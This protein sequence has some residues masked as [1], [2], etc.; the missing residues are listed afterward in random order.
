[1]TKGSKLVVFL[2]KNAHSESASFIIQA[3]MQ[4]TQHPSCSAWN[5]VLRVSE[6]PFSVMA[7]NWH[8]QHRSRCCLQFVRGTLHSGRWRAVAGHGESAKASIL[9]F[10]H[11]FN[12][13]VRLG[14]YTLTFASTQPDLSTD[15]SFTQAYFSLKL[16]LGDK[17]PH[18]SCHRF[19]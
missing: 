3:Y 8:C 2:L 16:S 4:S 11:R 12:C 10:W 19:C 5:I 9:C 1:V 7:M 13:V 6:P 14:S 18:L 15:A 17:N